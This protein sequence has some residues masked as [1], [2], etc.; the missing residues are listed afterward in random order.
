MAVHARKNAV[1][2]L[3]QLRM[4]RG[5]IPFRSA[6]PAQ[7]S[8]S[9]LAG[10]LSELSGEASSA[11]L[12]CAFSVVL[13]AQQQGEPVA[14]IT[15]EEAS[16]YP[17]DVAAFGVDLDSLTVVRLPEARMLTRAADH[18]GRSGAYGLIVVDLGEKARVPIPM[19]TRLN[20]LA[21]KNDLAILFLTQKT[22][23]SFSLGSL[24]ALRGS[25][26]REKVGENEFRCEVEFLKD[27]RRGPGW[28]HEEVFHG[29]DGLR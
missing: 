21:Q 20:G 1:I 22:E 15:T 29:P 5:L 16:F 6:P 23:E 19:Q 14:W 24:I 25:A 3:Q 12:T 4:Q 10:C 26:R 28:K 8:L 9:T 2:S 18:L 13:D 11:A 7:W 27:K 17:P